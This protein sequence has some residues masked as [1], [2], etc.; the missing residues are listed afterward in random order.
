MSNSS[1][2]SRSL[3]EISKAQGWDSTKIWDQEKGA[4][5]E[6][7]LPWDH[8]REVFARNLGEVPGGLPAHDQA[9]DTSGGP[10]MTE[11]IPFEYSDVSREARV[12]GSPKMTL[13]NPTEG[14]TGA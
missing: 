11:Q 5:T 12:S 3:I 13:A 6:S 9:K 4:Y 14:K 7:V 10:A 8:A 1:T 2:S